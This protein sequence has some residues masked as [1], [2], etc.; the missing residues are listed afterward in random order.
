MESVHKAAAVIV[1][2]FLTLHLS[3]HWVGLQGP[4]AHMAYMAVVR[5]VYR[6]P[7]AEAL[8]HI[9]LLIQIVTGWHLSVTIW[10]RKKDIAHQILA[11]SGVGLSVFILLHT[12]MS[13]GL[14]YG[15]QT[16]MT[17]YTVLAGFA[18][19]GWREL[20]FAFY[21]LGLGALGLHFSAIAFSMFK[22]VSRPL[23]WALMGVGIIGTAW[24]TWAGLTTLG[25]Q[26]AKTALPTETFS[27]Y[28]PFDWP[29]RLAIE[30]AS[31]PE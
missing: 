14:R 23:A 20:S 3:N 2:A 1:F 17:I 22:K 26:A 7:L 11:L 29:L 15:L 30:L 18:V 16:D 31:E 8:L 5:T 12:A 19:P 28:P 4:E 10:T 9:A 24:L 21:G 13:L 25:L 27:L 6:H